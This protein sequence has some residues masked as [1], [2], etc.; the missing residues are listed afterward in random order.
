MSSGNEVAHGNFSLIRSGRI[1]WRLST[2]ALLKVLGTDNG[3]LP[4]QYGVR[5]RGGVEPIIYQLNTW[6][7][8]RGYVETELVGH[9]PRPANVDTNDDD[10][11]RRRTPRHFKYCTS[12]D[13][14][15]LSTVS[16][17]PISPRPFSNMYQNNFEPWNG[18]KIRQ[19]R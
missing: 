12:L 16:V 18:P 4:H 15:K 14:K 2:K 13:F 7:K 9:A 19:P 3:L 6:Q 8:K 10:S 17:A 1:F 5:S 11:V